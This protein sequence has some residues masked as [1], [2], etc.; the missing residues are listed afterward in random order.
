MLR[1]GRTTYGGFSQVNQ[2]DERS[3]D[4][5]MQKIQDEI[6]KQYKRSRTINRSPLRY[7]ESEEVLGFG[8]SSSRGLEFKQSSRASPVKV[9]KSSKT[10][11][12][13]SSTKQQERLIFASP[14]FEE[15]NSWMQAIQKM[16][17]MSNGM[18]PELKQE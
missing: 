9:R 6:R 5:L 18:K 13:T 4:I 17:D 14:T 11:T 12:M 16:I 7:H 1:K 2:F 3:D 15:T 10:K 8:S